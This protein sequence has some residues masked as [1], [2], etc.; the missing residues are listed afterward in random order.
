MLSQRMSKETD[1]K[2]LATTIFLWLTIAATHAAE[3]S[4]HCRSVRDSLRQDFKSVIV[5][6]NTIVYFVQSRKNQITLDEGDPGDISIT[7]VGHKIRI[8]SNKIIPLVVTV[9]F[10]DIYCIEATDHAQI[11]SLGKVN[12]RNL[13]VILRDNAFGRIKANTTSLYTVTA[14]DSKL[15]LRGKTTEHF[16]LGNQNVNT[17]DFMASNTERRDHSEMIARWEK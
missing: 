14:G 16:V 7:K 6:G 8:S 2:T 17:S 12:L 1:M 4:N 15:E 13:Q 5:T 10:K 9:Y 3:T 11:R